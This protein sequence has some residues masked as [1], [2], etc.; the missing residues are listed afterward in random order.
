MSKRIDLEKPLSPEDR[1]YLVDRNRLREVDENEAR[2]GRN[3]GMSSEQRSARIAELESELATLRQE[4]AIEENPN[5]FQTRAG[6]GGGLKDNTNVDGKRPEGAPADPTDD[7]ETDNR[8]TA[9]ALKKELERRNAERAE[10]KLEPLSTSGNK[11]EL[12]ERLRM[13]D[14]E[15]AEQQDED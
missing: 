12:I 2:F 14:R 15:I 13:D 4:Q 10:A 8:W 1:Q 6:I 7:Y 9:G 3:S 5:V 11:S